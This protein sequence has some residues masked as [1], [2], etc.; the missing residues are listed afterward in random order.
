TGRR[1][2]PVPRPPE[3][4]G[5]HLPQPGPV[6]AGPGELGGGT[7]AAG[8]GGPLPAGGPASSGGGGPPFPRVPGGSLCFPGRRPDQVGQVRGGR[9]LPPEG[10]GPPGAAGEGVSPDPA[11]PVAVGLEPGRSGPRAHGAGTRQGG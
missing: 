6:A 9:N 5:Q 7:T 11:A 4:P 1:T 10:P 3:Q 2:P 8:Q